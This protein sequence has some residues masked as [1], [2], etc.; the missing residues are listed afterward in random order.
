MLTHELAYCP[1]KIAE[2]KNQD[3]RSGVFARVQLPQ[4]DVSRQALLRDGKPL[5]NHG[6]F[7]GHSRSHNV[8]PL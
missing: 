1:S 8:S 5:A 4:N 2:A 7:D 6:R 3:G